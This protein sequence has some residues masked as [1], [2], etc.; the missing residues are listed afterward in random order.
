M[1]SYCRE[2]QSKQTMKTSV[3]ICE[4]NPLHY[5]HKKL[6]DF[7]KS[8]SDNVVCV[9]SGN[10]VQRGMPACC[11]KYKRT[12]HALKAG[13]N[14]VVELPTIFATSSAENF[15]LGGVKIANALHADFLVFGSECGN[16][17]RLQE[18]AALL[19]QPQINKEIRK[20]LSKGLNYPTAVANA[21]GND[22]LEKPN[23]VL[24]VEY[25]RALK[26]TNSKATPITLARE[27]N[28]NGAPQEFASS[29][30]LRQNAQLRETFTFDFVACDINDQIE[31]DY[32]KF[33]AEFLALADKTTLEKTAGVTEGLHNRILAADKTQGYE[34]MMEEIKTKRYTQV[35][36]QRIVLNCVLGIDKAAEE[37]AKN[38]QPTP[39]VLG[40]AKG[41][42]KLLQG[43]CNQSD[44]LT[45]KADRLYAAL[46]G[47]TY[48]KKL[49]VW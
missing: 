39:K 36:L 37:A 30:A 41:S 22:V 48:P 31:S 9:M 27:D 8:F 16:L 19:E 28:F 4:L 14:L 21:C 12:L 46:E 1:L 29:S 45:Q 43:L 42:E 2:M 6:I 18:C 32:C 3:I 25:L 23:N 38:A 20:N 33:A 26:K 15:A 34:K 17:Q 44:E 10:F 35:K 24:A 13:A 11:N 40:V 49:L 47:E 7:A 5:G